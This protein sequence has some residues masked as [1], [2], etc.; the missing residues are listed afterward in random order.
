MD[1]LLTRYAKCL[2]GRQQV[3]N[4]R[5]DAIWDDG[6]DTEDASETD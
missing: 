1:V 4:Q 5:I 6:S 2:D 3:D